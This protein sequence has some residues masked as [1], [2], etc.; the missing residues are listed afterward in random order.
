MPDTPNGF[1]YPGSGSHTRIWE[2]MQTLAEQIDA[3]LNPAPVTFAAAPG[4]GWSVVLASYVKLGPLVALRVT[5][6]RTGATIT[7]A[8]SGNISPDTLI[9]S[10]LPAAIRPALT[11]PVPVFRTSETLGVALGSVHIR[12]NG[13][14]YLTDMY[15]SATIDTSLP[16]V[17]RG[18]YSVG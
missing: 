17:V 11:V 4:A 2:H 12:T 16:L 13:E 1:T 7:A 9:A 5:V 18:V 14:L 8:A 6:N 15:P 10:G 3:A